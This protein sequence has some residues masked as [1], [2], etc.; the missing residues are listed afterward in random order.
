MKLLIAFILTVSSFGAVAQLEKPF[1]GQTK[2]FVD[3]AQNCIQ[4][5][6]LE[7]WQNDSRYIHVA[8]RNTCNYVV[9]VYFHQPTWGDFDPERKIRMEK[10]EYAAGGFGL[11]PKSN[12]FIWRGA[13]T[14]AYGKPTYAFCR[15]GDDTNETDAIKAAYKD[16]KTKD[17]AGGGVDGNVKIN[18]GTFKCWISQ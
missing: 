11:P 16:P 5:M 4:Q 12:P 18:G 1:P 7:P 6:P 9:N 2:K 14:A 13:A 8:F 17:Y 15:H 10:G 3:P